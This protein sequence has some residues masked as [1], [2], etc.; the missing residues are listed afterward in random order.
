[1]LNFPILVYDKNAGVS[2]YAEMFSNHFAEQETS[3]N[4]D[5]CVP[6]PVA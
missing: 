3:L 1:M 6:H 2:L 5:N 4:V